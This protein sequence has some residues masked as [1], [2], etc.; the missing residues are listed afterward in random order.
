M[1]E[2]LLERIANALETIAA[3][4][5]P[6]NKYA[7]VGAAD[8]FAIY[9]SG[10]MVGAY[11]RLVVLYVDEARTAQLDF[12]GTHPSN[13]RETE[14]GRILLH[15]LMDLYGI[16]KE[17]MAFEK[18]VGSVLAIRFSGSRIT[19]FTRPYTAPLVARKL[20][21]IDDPELIDQATR[22]W[23]ENER[24]RVAALIAKMDLDPQSL[25]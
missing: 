10:E 12:Y 3:V 11:L 13:D 1:N 17:T 18:M 2:Q 25:G 15:Q 9:E 4:D 24:E 14:R 6:Y 8:L 7:R 5:G 20:P 16:T 23:A 19:G 21:P 22:E